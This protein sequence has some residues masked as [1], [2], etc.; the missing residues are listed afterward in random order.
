MRS[1]ET[2]PFQRLGIRTLI[3]MV[4]VVVGPMAD[5]VAQSSSSPAALR[6]TINRAF[7]VND[8]ESAASLIEVYLEQV[9]NDAAMLYNAA[10]AKSRLDAFDESASYLLRAMKAGFRDF[11]HMRDDPDLAGLKDHPTYRRIFEK[12]DGKDAARNQTAL[13]Q[14]RSQFD[15]DDYVYETDESRR[16]QYATALDPIAHL[17]MRQMLETEADHLIDTLFG[18]PPGYFVLIAVP[19]PDD[20]REFFQG[21]ASIGGIYQHSRRQLVARNIG[22]SLRHEFFHAMHYGH[23]ERLNQVHRLWVQEGMAS[24]YE[25]YEL[26]DDGEVTFLPNERQMITQSRARAGRLLRWEII[27]E[28]SPEEFM[29]KAGPLYPQVRSMFRYVAEHGKLVEWY[30]AYTRN[31]SSDPS[32]K[33]AFEQVF[34][35]S[36]R[37]IERDWR[38]WVSAEPSLDMVVRSG[39]ASLGIRSAPNLS[40]DGVVITDVLPRSAAGAAGLRRGDVIVAADGQETR[41]LRELQ[42]FIGAKEVGDLVALRVRRGDA[43][44]TKSVRLRP[45]AGGA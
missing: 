20:A 5:A 35:R 1:H 33:G 17:E 4:L 7:D 43:Y 13:A 2:T 38:K 45:F 31:F 39:D 14:W 3:L 16:I 32:G 18:A 10:C 27:F 12:L 11:A 24:L 44:V 19:R 15:S 25:N 6:R 40:N 30:R 9:P 34:D 8:Y 28:M 36:I 23:M 29:R 41:T 42:A 26:D 22:G 21:D 37:E